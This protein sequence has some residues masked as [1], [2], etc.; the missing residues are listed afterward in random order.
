MPNNKK[1]LTVSI[2]VLSVKIDR[3]GLQQ[4]SILELIYRELLGVN[5]NLAHT[6]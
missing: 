5:H 2:G 1:P 4:I 3:I 6:G